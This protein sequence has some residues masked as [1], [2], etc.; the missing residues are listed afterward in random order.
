MALPF[1]NS[2]VG[3]LGALSFWPLTVYF[4]IKMHIAQQEIQKGTTKWILLYVLIGVTF[5]VCCAV[6]V[7]AGAEMVGHLKEASPFTRIE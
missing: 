1:F 7:G 4:P 2:I 3:M 6:S 5:C